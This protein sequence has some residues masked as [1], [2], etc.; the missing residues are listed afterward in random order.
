VASILEAGPLYHEVLAFYEKRGFRVSAFRTI[1]M[2]R[3]ERAQPID[4]PAYDL[5]LR[6]DEIRGQWERYYRSLRG[7]KLDAPGSE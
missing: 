1:V 7:G 2:V 6:E 4:S 3:V 5:G